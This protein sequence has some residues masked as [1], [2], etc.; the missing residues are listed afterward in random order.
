M[1]NQTLDQLQL[2]IHSGSKKS[3]QR[4]LDSLSPIVNQFI[5]FNGGHQKPINRRK[6][7]IIEN[8]AMELVYTGAFNQ[9]IPLN[10]YLSKLLGEIFNHQGMREQEVS[11]SKHS[12]N[13]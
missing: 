7:R 6:K 11:P 3:R 5:S 13:L 9:T 8:I 4:L 10:E 2:G 1:G 12:S